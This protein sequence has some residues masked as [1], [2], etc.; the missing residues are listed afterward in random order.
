MENEKSNFKSLIV[1][2]TAMSLAADVYK[3]TYKLPVEERYALSD[4]MK[5]SAVSIPSNIAEGKGRES[6]REFSHFLSIARGSSTELETQVLLCVQLG[7][8]QQ[9]EVKEILVKIDSIQR[10]ITKMKAKLQ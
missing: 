7:Y 4:Q 2:Q 10:M 1:W 8:Y 5:R 9:D 3:L 6:D